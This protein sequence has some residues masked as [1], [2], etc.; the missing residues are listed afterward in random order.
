MGDRQPPEAE[1]EEDE[2][3]AGERVRGTLD[4][5]V[6]DEEA[7]AQV[8]NRV[9][10]VLV[11]ARRELLSEMRR[12]GAEKVQVSSRGAVPDNF[13]RDLAAKAL[14]D[15]ELDELERVQLVALF[16]VQKL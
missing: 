14:G 3:V 8:E 9:G 13:E 15:A 7:S 5:L 16:A 11:D 2:L 10:R 12:D 1:R 6:L 4:R